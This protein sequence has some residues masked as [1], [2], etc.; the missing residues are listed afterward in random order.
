MIAARS[1]EPMRSGTTGARAPALSQTRIQPDADRA[2]PAGDAA[3]ARLLRHDAP[4]RHLRIGPAILGNA[5][6]QAERRQRLR[7]AVDRLAAELGHDDVAGADGHARRC[8]EEHEKG[9]DQRAGEYQ[10][11]P[12][13]PHAS[14]Q[15]HP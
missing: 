10:H 4:F 11:P 8:R 14:S 2:R 3:G 13:A 6:R 15:R 1:D 5:Q 12:D 9:H 7:G